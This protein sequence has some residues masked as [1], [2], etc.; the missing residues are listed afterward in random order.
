MRI[1]LVS[2]STRGGGAA[3]AALRLFDA[4]LVLGYEVRMLTISKEIDTPRIGAIA[5][6]PLSR[7]C[8][9]TYRVLERLELM[10]K[11]GKQRR[12]LWRFSTASVGF[13]ISDHPWVRW[14]DVLHLHWIN[15]GML[16]LR[17]LRGL[18]H[19]GKPIAWT[20]HDLWPMT[21]GCHLPFVWDKDKAMLCQRYNSGCGYCP[22]LMSDQEGDFT[23][24]LR[25]QK[26][27]LHL[28]PFHYIAVSETVAQLASQAMGRSCGV[29]IPPPLSADSY[30]LEFNVE[31]P[32]WYQSDRVYLL[33]SAARLDDAVK[34]PQ[35]LKQVMH[36]L[37]HIAPELGSYV[38]LLL[39][40][41]IKQPEIFADMPIEVRCLGLVP[42]D[43]M[44]YFYSLAEVVLSTSLFETYGQT[45][46]EA[47]AQGVPV[48][49]FAFGGPCDIVQEGV[50]GALVVPYDVS[51]YAQAIVKVLALKRKGYITQEKCRESVAHLLPDVIALRH[52]DYYQTLLETR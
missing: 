21:G 32:L 30:D 51:A 44:R 29:V 14:A 47:L 2:R 42:A 39:V 10:H 49:S 3:H 9:E 1:L 35:L 40:G 6:T 50:N 48:V 37:M 36:A 26:S 22:L 45:L 27:F 28:S 11:L 24:R 18:T 8:A 34:G 5:N 13:D 15:H 41:E 4:L 20:L 16:S 43:H 7:L 38:T 17:D 23:H 52:I 46:T 12:L 33:I 31:Y 19:L 25:A